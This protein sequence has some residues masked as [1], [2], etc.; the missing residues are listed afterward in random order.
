MLGDVGIHILD[1]ATFIAGSDPASISCFLATFDKAPGDRIGEYVL[2]AND[3]VTMQLRLDNGALGT[4]SAT[5]FASGHLNDLRLRL[6]GD[7]GGIEVL[8]ENQVSRLNICREA[9]MQSATWTEVPTDDVPKV[10]DRFIAAI[11]GQGD[12]Q[13]DFARGAALQRVLDAAERSAAQGG[14]AVSLQGGAAA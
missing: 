13:P 12:G 7:K 5:R 3:S 4:V 1:Y 11:R 8:F 2:D 10:Y 14:C 6:Y 9:D